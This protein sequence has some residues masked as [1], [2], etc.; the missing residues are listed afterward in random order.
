MTSN[1]KNL[2]S[3]MIRAGRFNAELAQMLRQKMEA[4]APEDEE[5]VDGNEFNDYDTAAINWADT[6][7]ESVVA[8]TVMASIQAS[9]VELQITDAT[10]L[11]SNWAVPKSYVDTK[12]ASAFTDLSTVPD[13]T[14]LTSGDYLSVDIDQI[15]ST[16][17]GANAVVQI[18]ILLGSCILLLTYFCIEKLSRKIAIF[19]LFISSI[20]LAPYQFAGWLHH[21]QIFIFF[22]TFY[23]TIL[24]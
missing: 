4:D 5:D 14:S 21:D 16:V 20:T 23:T 6:L 12:V 19:A 18:Q 11:Q 1:D 2:L 8:D 3:Q 13:V 24:F 10:L 9:H 22:L 17:A 15:G 7:L